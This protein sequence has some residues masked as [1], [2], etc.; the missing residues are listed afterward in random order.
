MK[1]SLRHI[2]R[3]EVKKLNE[4][5]VQYPGDGGVG[6][7]EP[8][9]GGGGG[10]SWDLA[11]ELEFTQMMLDQMTMDALGTLDV[12]GLSNPSN[13]EGGEEGSPDFGGGYYGADDWDMDEEEVI[14]YITNLFQGY[15]D[16][17]AEFWIQQDIAYL[18]SLNPGMPEFTSATNAQLWSNTPQGQQYNV[19]Q[20]VMVSMCNM[21]ENALQNTTGAA[22][23]LYQDVGYPLPW[24][25]E[26]IDW[27]LPWL[28]PGGAENVEEYCNT[29]F[30]PVGPSYLPQSAWVQSPCTQGQAPTNLGASPGTPG[31]GITDYFDCI[32]SY[33]LSGPDIGYNPPSMPIAPDD[34]GWGC[35]DQT[36][37]NYNPNA[38][39]DCFYHCNPSLSGPYNDGVYDKCPCDYTQLQTQ[40]EDCN[41]N[42]NPAA[43]TAF[44]TFGGFGWDIN[45]ITGEGTQFCSQICDTSIQTDPL[46]LNH[47]TSE[48]C[49]C[50][51]A[52]PPPPQDPVADLTTDPM[53]DRRPSKIPE[54]KPINKGEINESTKI[55]LQEL[56]NIRK[57]K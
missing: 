32:N 23:V 2:I 39:A 55:R 51:D 41:P 26:N 36:A 18:D 7:E 21:S 28:A 35:M 29:M 19:T 38:Q 1:K 24:C 15:M 13:W 53:L 8:T 16:D 42:T 45:T 12:S 57:R 48:Y 27:D 9:G 49:Y 56:A 34:S 5:P 50:C 44:N 40:Q 43:A 52:S 47:P 31:A 33:T 37:A 4:I 6:P 30:P 20:N 25:G 3:E 14:A 11:T 22:L 54:K 10:T 46:Y 17:Y